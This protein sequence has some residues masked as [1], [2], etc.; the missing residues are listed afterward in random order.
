VKAFSVE[1]FISV[2][3]SRRRASVESSH[4]QVDPPK[5]MRNS[6]QDVRCT[7]GT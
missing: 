4:C 5:I 7:S 2:D 3:S 1:I 6:D